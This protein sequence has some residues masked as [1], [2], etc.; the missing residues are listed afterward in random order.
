[1]HLISR[2]ELNNKPEVARKYAEEM[3]MLSKKINYPTGLAKGYDNLGFY[4]G[5]KTSLDS[6]I[7]YAKK[8]K[9]L[10]TKNIPEHLRNNL[11]HGDLYW[12]KKEYDSSFHFLNKNINLYK[13]RD[14]SSIKQNEEFKKWMGG[15]YN[16]LGLIYMG[17][18]KY[19]LALKNQL[20][21]LKLFKEF[22]E[23]YYSAVIYNNMGILENELENYK[24]ALIY[25][26]EAEKLFRLNGKNTMF[27]TA[28]MNRIG[29]LTVLNEPDK[30]LQLHKEAIGLAQKFGEK[31]TEA[32]L[33]SNLGIVYADLKKDEK[34]ITSYLRALTLYK[35][36]NMED[37]TLFLSIG[38]YYFLR[39]KELDSAL[40]Y[41][42]KTIKVAEAQQ[43]LNN[44]SKAY[45]SRHDLY[46]QKGEYKK[47]LADYEV[48]AK[49]NDNLFN[50]EKSK[51]IEELRAGYDTEK[52]EQQ[53]KIQK[54][55]IEVLTIKEKV[56]NMQ[57]L[58]LAF[59][60][61]IALIGLYAI[62]QRNK[63]NKLA[64]EKAEIDLE[65]KTKELTTHALHLA[66]KNEVL[67]DIKKKAKTFK[68]DAG[69]DAG[70]QTLIQ[71]IDFD[72]QD[73]NSW[74]NFST[75]FEEVH[76]DF[77]TKAQQQFPNITS[78]DLRLMALIKMNL[79][80]KEIANILNISG[81]GIK[82]ARQRLRKK[83]EL[84]L[85]DS[86]ETVIIAI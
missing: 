67:N 18:G 68:T 9:L 35:N 75:Y 37:I 69:S 53:I 76:K 81:N 7:I 73:D 80:S 48:Y 42:N 27:L 30:A 85:T 3:I 47:A 52:K 10:M 86:L 56:S 74:S 62:Y 50:K 61:L 43:D 20:K 12:R 78:K 63:R 23:T 77:N 84:E 46:K 31:L 5:S 83:M 60:L 2:L 15:T 19:P 26:E 82:K 66:K 38:D 65:Y 17:T 58:L 36:L 14:S 25:Y 13:N 49:L 1:M 71:T 29:I 79:S 34:A 22:G 8:A 59:S 6:A 72:I 45:D 64:K 28:M 70:Y 32:K 24:Q 55:E 57:R 16:M 4:F 11:L 41:Y 39:K 21:A 40:Y 51:Q 33:W 54:Q 44:L